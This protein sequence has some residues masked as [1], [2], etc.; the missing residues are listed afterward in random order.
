MPYDDV[1]D[2]VAVTKT[3]VIDELRC[4]YV[5]LRTTADRIWH[6]LSY[7]AMQRSQLLLKSPTDLHR[8]LSCSTI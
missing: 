1:T 5:T 2:L 4:G 6:Q 7:R 3:N 8:D